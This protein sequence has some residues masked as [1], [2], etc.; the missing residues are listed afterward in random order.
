MFNTIVP[1]SSIQ[2]SFACCSLLAVLQAATTGITRTPTACHPGG[3]NFLFADGSVRFL[4]SSISIHDLLGAG[5]QGQR[6]G[7]LVRQ[8]LTITVSPRAGLRC[9]QRVRGSTSSA[10]RELCMLPT[11][12]ARW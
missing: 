12:D 9:R 1:P 3:A 10:S 5:D 6:R 2:Y 11:V 4:K 7:H 8:L